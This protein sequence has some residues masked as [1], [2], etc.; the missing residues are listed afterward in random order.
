[1]TLG[2]AGILYYEGE[3]SSQIAIMQ[4]NSIYKESLTNLIKKRISWFASEYSVKIAD[5]FNHV[6]LL[7]N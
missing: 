5:R 6:P 2:L 3:V 4:G 7:V 1:M